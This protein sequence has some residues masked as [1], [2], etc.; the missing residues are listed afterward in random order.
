MPAAAARTPGRARGR[1]WARRGGAALVALVLVLLLAA[2]VVQVVLTTDYPRSRVIRAVEDAT[3]LAVKAGSLDVGWFGGST[4]RDVTFRL[5]LSDDPLAV[6]PVVRVRHSSVPAILSAMDVEVRELVI[7]RPTLT[8]V[9]SRP[10]EWNILE[11]RDQI[12]SIQARKAEAGRGAVALPRLLIRGGT[13]EVARADGRRATLP[14][15]FEGEPRGRLAWEFAGDLGDTLRVDGKFSPH[16]QWA[17]QVGFRIA[18]PQ[19][20]LG[21]FFAQPLRA[22]AVSG[23]WRG[24]RVGDGVDGWLSLERL[25]AAG[26]SLQGSLEATLAG[27]TVTVRPERLTLLH[28][29]APDLRLTGGTITLTTRGADWSQLAAALPNLAVQLSGAWD[30]ATGAVQTSAV[31]R[32]QNEDLTHDGSGEITA[33]LPAIGRFSLS[34]TLR[35]AG[36][37]GGNEWNARATVNADGPEWRGA[38]ARVALPLGEVRAGER[39]IDLSGLA[40]TLRADWPSLSLTALDLPGARSTSASGDADALGGE[41][42]L[43]VASRGVDVPG[44]SPEPFDL[45]LESRGDGRRLEFSRLQ[46]DGESLRIRAAGSYQPAQAQRPA[47]IAEGTL[48]YRMLQEVD[49]ASLEEVPAAAGL[50]SGSWDL[51]GEVHPLSLE[52]GA[53]VRGQEIPVGRGI[54]DEVTIPLHGAVTPQTVTLAASEVDLLG[55]MWR[56]NARY[57]RALSYLEAKFDIVGAEMADVGALMVPGVELGGALD[58]SLT[59]RLPDL[60]AEKAQ[61]EG[62]WEVRTL[63]TPAGRA[64]SARGRIATREGRVSITELAATEGEGTL[65]GSIESNLRGDPDIRLDLKAERW[66]AAVPALRM[67]FLVDGEAKVSVDPH[68]R[69]AV[70]DVLVDAVARHAGDGSPNA[71]AAT[72]PPMDPIVGRLE[73]SARLT[74]RTIE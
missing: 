28:P 13:V 66:P 73:V 64:A 16:A 51:R 65:S 23:T 63:R 27:E 4:L 6:A 8:V 56:V 60:D 15:A 44:V 72:P 1:R 2:L 59:L 36:R 46:V 32:G 29:A 48:W 5:P 10:G 14:L 43:S 52:L 57:E 22:A 34:A 26:F 71:G 33:A 7:E 11:A 31:W 62:R 19:D 69:R 30:R 18:D 49:P 53:R 74:G 40:A 47:L 24:R 9:E 58:S 12:V 25:D 39:T 45:V 41:W 70:G 20:I 21:L 3:G 17:H 35:S 54:V 42:R 68:R 38:T 37:W 67:E 50:W 55:G 61:L